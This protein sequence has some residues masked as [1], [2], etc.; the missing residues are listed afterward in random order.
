MSLAIFNGS[1]RGQKSNSNVI[2]KWFLNG[3]RKDNKIFFLNKVKQY[4]SYL[5]EASL[6]DELLFIMPLYVDGMPG[7]VKCFFE[8]MHKYKNQFE[9]KKVT[10]II[11]SGF[12]EGIQNRSLET[13]LNRY[14]EIMNMTNHGV[15][16]LPGSEGFRLMPPS[17]TKKKN[18][19]VSEL[20]KC[21]MNSKPYD[22]TLKSKLIKNEST[23]KF[24][25]ICFTVFSK[26]GL[27]NMYWNGELKKNNAYEKRFDAPYSANPF[28]TQ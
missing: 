6:Y 27:T 1:P 10:F 8:T 4:E 16:I 25:K 12:G 9:N 19:I 15:I 3:Y 26:L 7:Q 18:K 11:H 23:S 22:T 21:Y 28:D 20:G 2:T 13:Y 5:S 24:G 14:A 17:M